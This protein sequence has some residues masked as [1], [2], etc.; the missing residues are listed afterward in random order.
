MF[1]WLAA[2]VV[3]VATIAA[4]ILVF[5]IYP[6]VPVFVLSLVI[7]GTRQHGLVVL[8]HDGA[9]GSISKNRKLNDFLSK[10]CFLPFGIDLRAYRKFHFA[11]HKF[12]GTDRDPERLLKALA[13]P[14]YGL[15]QNPILLAA[16][17]FLI[18]PTVRETIPLMRLISSFRTSVV[19]VLFWSIVTYLSGWMPVLVWF[20]ALSTSFWASNRLR[21]WTEHQGNM[22]N[23]ISPVWW[24]KVLYLPH[25]IWVHP[26]HHNDAS[27]PYYRLP[28]IRSNNYPC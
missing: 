22:Y 17:D 4:A 27:I 21:I 23:Y 26:E 28:V 24:Q 16:K 18:W 8:G 13:Y 2:V 20:T 6:N 14:A 11:H 15:S 19:A 10:I 12:L 1:R 25:N 9:H 5:K 7:V 3:D